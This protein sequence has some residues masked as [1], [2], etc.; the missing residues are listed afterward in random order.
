MSDPT[1]TTGDEV[2]GDRIPAVITDPD[3]ELA[4][5]VE[6]ANSLPTDDP[7]VIQERILRALMTATTAEDIIRAGEAVPAAEV[8]GIPL[9]IMAIR[10]SESTFEDGPN[11]YLHVDAKIRSNGDS[12]TFSC[13]ARDVVTKLIRLDQLRMLPVD[14]VVQ[15]SAKPTGDGFYPVFLRMA[16]PVEEPFS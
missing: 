4:K 16:E 5:F 14:A 8:L 1:T 15:K 7:E 9:T 3:S 10:G 11:L 12:I 13:G 2:A 6:Y